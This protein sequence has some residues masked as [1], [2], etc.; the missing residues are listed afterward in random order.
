MSKPRDLFVPIDIIARSGNHALLEGGRVPTIGYEVGRLRYTGDGCIVLIE[1]CFH[2]GTDRRDLFFFEEKKLTY[3][4]VSIRTA[5][6]EYITDVYSECARM[7]KKITP[8][9][10]IE[11]VCEEYVFTQLG[12]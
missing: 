9:E 6:W 3:Q 2:Y 7:R 10:F 11:M 5:E 12:F 4:S 1:I 8:E